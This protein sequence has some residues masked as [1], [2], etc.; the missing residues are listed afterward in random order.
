MAAI[1]LTTDT[2]NLTSISNDSSFDYVFAKQVQALG[3]KGDV[4]IALTTS[5]ISK[6]K[7]GHSA[8]IYQ[9]I[10]A[11]KEKGMKVIGLLSEKSVEIGKMVDL[12]IHVPNKDTARIQEM[13]ITIL[14]IICDLVERELFG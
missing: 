10:Q 6:E 4:V 8:N 3:K 13:H 5:D 9:G 1:A 14:H 11:A 2:S 12:A 7:G